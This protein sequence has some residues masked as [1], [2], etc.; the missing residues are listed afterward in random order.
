VSHLFWRQLSTTFRTGV[1][2]TQ[3]RACAASQP[4]STRSL[5]ARFNPPVRLSL[6]G[7]GGCPGLARNVSFRPGCAVVPSRR[8]HSVRR[9]RRY[10]IGVGIDTLPDA[11]HLPGPQCASSVLYCDF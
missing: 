5:R 7:R 1:M 4:M 6:S 10:E 11:D 2:G 9:K 3:T 8:R